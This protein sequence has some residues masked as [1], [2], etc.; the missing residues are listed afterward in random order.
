MREGSTRSGVFGELEPQAVEPDWPSQEYNSQ[1][2][3]QFRQTGGFAGLTKSG[4]FDS[5]SMP[6]EEAQELAGLVEQADPSKPFQESGSAFQGADRE[7][8]SIVIEASGKKHALHLTQGSIPDRLRP[9]VTF[10]R[11]RSKYEKR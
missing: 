6:E 11:K 9:L 10:L 2:K 7:Q 3:I 4:N 8:Y 1:M 5:D